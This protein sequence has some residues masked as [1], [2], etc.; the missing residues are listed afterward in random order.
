MKKLM[1]N[2]RLGLARETL[3]NLTELRLKHLHQA[4]GGVSANSSEVGCLSDG[5]CLSTDW[6]C[7]GHGG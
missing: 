3:K 1:P 6:S 7:I 4:Q 5:G 2:K